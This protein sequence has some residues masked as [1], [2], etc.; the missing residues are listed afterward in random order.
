MLSMAENFLEISHYSCASLVVDSSVTNRGFDRAIRMKITSHIS[1][2]R[3][4]L[5]LEQEFFFPPWHHP[6]KMVS[7]LVYYVCRIR[8]LVT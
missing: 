1:L 4:H 6:I 7:L 8:F 3:S 5:F 2:T